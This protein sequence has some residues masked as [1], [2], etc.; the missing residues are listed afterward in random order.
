MGVEVGQAADRADDVGRLVHDDDRRGAETRFQLR[1][2]VEIHRR[3]DDLLGGN[4]PHRGAT[5]NDRLEVVPAAADAA[6]M[7]VDELS[8]RQPKRLFDIA[9]R[10]DVAGDAEDARAGVRK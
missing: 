9:G 6:A 4:H 5:G 10:V 3:V 1:E 2:R 7:L 8:E